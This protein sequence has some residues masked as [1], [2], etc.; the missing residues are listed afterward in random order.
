M[1]KKLHLLVLTTAIA[2][3]GTTQATLYSPSV[4][5]RINAHGALTNAS[6]LSGP[7]ILDRSGT[8][9]SFGVWTDYGIQRAGSSLAL[10]TFWP[11]SVAYGSATSKWTDALRISTPD[12][13]AGQPVHFLF[14]IRLDGHLQA[15]EDNYTN[16]ITGVQFNMSLNEHGSWITQPSYGLNI[17]PT[18]STTAGGDASADVDVTL[19]G[20]FVVPNGLWFNLISSLSTSAKGELMGPPGGMSVESLFDNSAQWLGGSVWANGSPVSSFMIESGSGFDYSQAA[21]PVPAAC[22]LFGSGLLGLIS[23]VR[24]NRKVAV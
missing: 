17:Q 3:S 21:I 9:Y 10:A 19:M 18:P 22:W 24:Q 11:P 16:A 4:E 23:R 5:A 8:H 1:N 6:Q 20:E 7:V 15:H 12:V 13:A 2:F 14:S